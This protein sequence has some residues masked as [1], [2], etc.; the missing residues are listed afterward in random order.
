[1]ASHVNKDFHKWTPQQTRRLIR[2]RTDN[3]HLFSQ[4][5]HAV[6][7]LWESLIQE[8]GLQGLVTPQ[9]VSKKW[10][11]LKK[12][13]KELGT[14]RPGGRGV[15][16]ATWQF[17]EDMQE[18]L[19]GVPALEPPVIVASFDPEADYTCFQLKTE[20]FEPPEAGNS[21]G[22]AS[23]S[24]PPESPTRSPKTKRVRRSEPI[25]DFLKEESLKEQRR[26]EESEAKVDRFLDL[27][28]RLIDKI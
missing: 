3:E 26:H 12:K 10:E 24:A 1:M 13:Y 23:P 2:F 7:P 9:Q 22:T 21:S 28:Q 18:A 25:L 17:F 4:S 15:A 11:N 27:F 14:P 16:V 6:K 8:L 19:G 20:D 5:K